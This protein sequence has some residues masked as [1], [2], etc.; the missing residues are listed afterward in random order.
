M[1]IDTNHKYDFPIHTIR[2][3]GLNNM[4]SYIIQHK[5]PSQP[6]VKIV[7][8]VE[9]FDFNKNIYYKYND[10]TGKYT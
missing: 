5:V 2:I 8:E 7:E 1:G 6:K 3:D 4:T 10:Y 9:A